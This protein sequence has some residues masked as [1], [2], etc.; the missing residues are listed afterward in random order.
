LAFRDLYE[1]LAPGRVEIWRIEK[2]ASLKYNYPGENT[3]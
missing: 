2:K 3:I 1:L